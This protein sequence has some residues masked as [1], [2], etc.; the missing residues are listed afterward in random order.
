M[1]ELLGM[2]GQRSS[3]MMPAVLRADWFWAAFS[4]CLQS[5][6]AQVRP[7]LA[8][9]SLNPRACAQ[10]QMLVP[11]S[12]HLRASGA[13][14]HDVPCAAA[15]HAVHREGCPVH[16]P[17]PL[18]ASNAGGPVQ[19]QYEACHALR[20]IMEAAEAHAH[21]DAVRAAQ[22]AEY[23][24]AIMSE[25]G[26]PP[27]SAQPCTALASKQSTDTL[28]KPCPVRADAHALRLRCDL[29][30]GCFPTQQLQA[31]LVQQRLRC[32]RSV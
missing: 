24:T 30:A 31:L 3:I 20:L 16:H 22:I 15:A 12:V 18:L 11:E 19:V 23:L 25:L 6:S 2:L 5:T 29:C 27:C 14:L 9:M 17:C 7:V 13:Q 28:L 1:A 26:N 10:G 32:H 4:S 21:I 8:S